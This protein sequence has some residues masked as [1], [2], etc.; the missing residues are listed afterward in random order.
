MSKTHLQLK[1]A[2]YAVLFVLLLGAAGMTKAN[3]Q[4]GALNGLFS[5]ND[6][7][8][9]RFSLGNLQYQASTNT[10]QFAENQWNYVG[11][12]NS[13]ISETYDGWIDLFGW[14]TGNNPTNTSTSNADYPEPFN[15]W[16]NNAISNGGNTENSG[17]RTLTNAE[18]QYVFNT[19]PGIRYAKAKVADV[20]GVILLPD[21]WDDS[22]YTLSST[23]IADANY[24][25]NIISDT[26]WPML[27]AAGA[28]FLPAAGYRIG[29]S[30]IGAG[31]YG[32]YWSASP[33]GGTYAYGVYFFDGYLSPGSNN[34]RYYG[35]SVRLV[36][37]AENYTFGITATASP[38]EG[39]TVSGSGAYAEGTGC[40]L[41]AT[42]A[43]GYTFLNWTE[44]GEVV[45]TENP[46][47]FT[48]TGER[49][50]I[51]HFLNENLNI[52][53]E[54]LIAYYPFNGNANDE[55]GN[56]NHGVLGGANGGP[57]LT[58][59]RFGNENSCYEFGGYYNS[60]WIDVP[61]SS[62]L[63][64]DTTVSVSFWVQECFRGGTDGWGGFSTEG[65]NYGVI[66]KG[67][68]GF[69]CPP[70]LWIYTSH[71][72][73]NEEGFCGTTVNNSYDYGNYAIH[74][75]TAWDSS[76][77]DCDWLHCVVIIEGHHLSFYHNGVMVMDTIMENSADFSAANNQDMHIGIEGGYFWNPRDGKLDDIIIYNRALTSQEVQLLYGGHEYVDLGLPSG[78]LWATC[79]VGATAPEE[80]GDYFAW[81][82]T[83]TKEDYSYSTYQYCNGSYNT[84]TKYCN[85][86]SY[87][88]NGYTDTL[89]LLLPTDDAATAQWGA[90]WRMPTYE[91]WQELLDNTTNTWTTQNGVNGR[92]FTAAN[93]ASLFLPDAGC[94]LNSEIFAG[95][96][97]FYWSGSLYTGRPDHAWGFSF[98]SDGTNMNYPGRN[99]GQSVRPVRSASQDI[100]TYW[101]PNNIDYEENMPITAV[102]EIDGV[103]QQSTTL[104]LGAFSGEECRGSQMAVYFEPTQRY[105]YQMTVFGEEGDEITFRL[106]DH[107]TNEELDLVAPEAVA[108]NA[109]GYGNLPNPIVLN[110]RHSYD[111]N[112]TANPAEGGTVDGGGTY[113]HGDVCTLTAT[114]NTNYVFVN[115]TLD[116]EVVSTEAEYSF[117]VT[118]G[119]EYTAHFDLVQTL[120]FG[121]GW[122]WWSTY[123]GQEGTE[124]LEALE[125]GLGANGSIVK[126]QNEGYVSYMDGYGWYGT[127]ERLYNEQSYRVQANA[128]C[129]VQLQGSLIDPADY[130][131]TLNPG[132]TWMGFPWS[133]SVSVESALQGFEP[134]ANDFIKGRNA[135]TMYY[136]E[137]GYSMWFG[138]LNSLEP[139]QG[140][141]YYSNSGEA[142]TLTL[143]TNGGRSAQPNVTAD[144]NLFRPEAGAYADNM[145]LTA[146][147]NLNDEE[148]HSEAYEVA[149]FCNGECRGSAKLVYFAPKD[150]H[151]AFLTLYG[152]AD[153]ELEFV[154]TDGTTTV[155]SGNA[156]RFVADA[157][158]GT[159]AEPY[160][161]YFGFLGVDSEA[162]TS[163][164]VYPNPTKDVFNVEGVGIRR[165]EVFNALG[166]IVASELTETENH[167]ID[168][169]GVATGVYLLR[170]VTE[171]GV[172]T[173]RIVKE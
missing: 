171:N 135:Y 40:T 126:A 12:A 70:G 33:D 79:N 58:T 75:I 90:G 56:G 77:G 107:A 143:N 138:P 39:G 134:E 52:P 157:H 14:G 144:G 118:S 43:E 160:T 166:Q 22:T 37:P 104:E 76:V 136:A 88:N 114:P 16:G 105:I 50:L 24:S 151:I 80:Y 128:A 65:Y 30:V 116:G 29:T 83:Q 121:Q 96:Y 109:F 150:C 9:V 44:N 21:D 168:L 54:G 94:R 101:T 67:G 173:Q 122:N 99:T 159:L 140:Y 87:G 84:L 89:T 23:N 63:Q 130:P 28:V 167:R 13:N 123:I 2:L 3:A 53:T 125:N 120:S 142:K 147:V 74:D 155:A 85:D 1:R 124:G 164:K 46:Y 11:E 38:A 95:S 48:V 97:G 60:N 170:I 4:T 162:Q 161:L 98:S 139:G 47:S 154:L 42:P 73:N 61:N 19:R 156:V 7:T 148:L 25:S 51:A 18:W 35:F 165:I 26:D 158:L 36:C 41:T 64:L 32:G 27:E 115:W 172:T 108:F 93:G 5:V 66:A 69:S 68:D 71:D 103:E 110:F 112:A 62:S 131:I 106:Y 34:N 146:L 59:D 82:E 169:G 102:V 55:S 81:G 17:W 15:D 31:S 141:V 49:D 6:S 149:A 137:G 153:D 78:T 133:Q 127:L 45:S 72:I 92:L 100:T 152:D 163:V 111:I 117:E 8:Q 132:W 86:G 10:W 113:L 20:S 57:A 119:G 91:E 145:T 129:T